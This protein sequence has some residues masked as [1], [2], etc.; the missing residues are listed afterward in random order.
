MRVMSVMRE[1]KEKEKKEKILRG[2]PSL[3][4]D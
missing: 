3:K 2:L 4:I 1:W